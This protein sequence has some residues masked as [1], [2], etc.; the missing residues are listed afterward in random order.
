MV[1][2]CH[3]QARFLRD[4]LVEEGQRGND[5]ARMCYYISKLA[6]LALNFAGSESVSRC[7]VGRRQGPE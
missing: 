3:S 5:I 7:A 2:L 1:H 6:R 4:E